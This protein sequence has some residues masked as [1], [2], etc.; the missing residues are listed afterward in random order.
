[1]Y[2]EWWFAPETFTPDFT[3]VEALSASPAVVAYWFDR[4]DTDARASMLRRLLASVGPL[5]LAVVADGV[6]AKY[7]PYART[8][9]LPVSFDDAARTTSNHVAELVRYLQQSN[10]QLFG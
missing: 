9:E 5:A 6:F 8:P 2:R 10:P 3:D 4:L 7:V 1:M